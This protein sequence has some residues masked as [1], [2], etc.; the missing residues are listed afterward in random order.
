MTFLF[1]AGYGFADVQLAV[2]NYYDY[3]TNT[4]SASNNA[5]MDVQ[6]TTVN[7]PGVA[8][9]L[10]PVNNARWTVQYLGNSSI[11]NVS[12]LNGRIWTQS[13]SEMTA[14][15]YRGLVTA[16]GNWVRVWTFGA[17]NGFCRVT[18]VNNTQGSGVTR[19]SN[20]PVISGSYGGITTGIN[21]I[22]NSLSFFYSPL[23]GGILPHNFSYA[24]LPTTPAKMNINIDLYWNYISVLNGTRN[25]ASPITTIQEGD[26]AITYLQNN[27]DCQ[28]LFTNYTTSGG[29]F[30][31]PEPYL[32]PICS[33]Q[34]TNP[35]ALIGAFIVNKTDPAD[36]SSTRFKYTVV[37]AV[38][39]TTAFN[40]LY[41]VGH[42][43]TNPPANFNTTVSFYST[44]AGD[45][46]LFYRYRNVTDNNSESSFT[47]WFVQTKSENVTVHNIV[48]NSANI[49]DGKFY[50]YF[51]GSGTTNNTNSGNY[52]N[53]T[54]GTFGSGISGGV[55]STGNGT[56]TESIIN[57]QNS[58][59]C[60]GSSC[61]WLFIGIPILAIFTIL[62]WYFGG[63]M[64]GK[65]T[66]LALLTIE[67]IAGLLPIFV[68]IPIIILVAYLIA[69]MFGVFGGVQGGN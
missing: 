63:S 31:L 6:C 57:L 20:T 21:T 8:Q 7:N 32:T 27:L 42:V 13:E 16:Q 56:L 39:N 69:R 61:I 51:V 64:L 68:I 37:T 55:S 67:S 26:P 4:T 41:G 2:T 62:A 30:N 46:Q 10:T 45:T 23:D 5:S 28:I 24:G 58:G 47:G 52:Y 66:F 9:R 34:D 36:G 12:N 19:M 17:T 65:A 53:F 25:G 29:G 49:L 40:I 22:N 35:F 43:P 60:T 14:S 3:E 33:Y 15:Q 59:L 48:I 18:E 54:V 44:L 11:G 38:Y 50:Q 1:F